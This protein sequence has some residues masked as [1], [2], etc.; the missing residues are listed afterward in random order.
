MIKYKLL[1]PFINS[2]TYIFNFCTVNVFY[3]LRKMLNKHI[4]NLRFEKWL[5]KAVHT[6]QARLFPDAGLPELN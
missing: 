6:A 4:N 1:V 2:R 3:K 5:R